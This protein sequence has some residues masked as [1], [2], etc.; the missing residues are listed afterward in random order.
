VVHW[1]AEDSHAALKTTQAPGVGVPR[2]DA[3][4]DTVSR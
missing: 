2:G 1:T 4:I 3:V